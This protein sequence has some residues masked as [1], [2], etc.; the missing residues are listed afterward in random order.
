VAAVKISEWAKNA[1]SSKAV[2]K[3]E[4]WYAFYWSTS[5]LKILLWFTNYVYLWWQVISAASEISML[6]AL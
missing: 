3:V 5:T 4:T 1:G 6:K 2:K